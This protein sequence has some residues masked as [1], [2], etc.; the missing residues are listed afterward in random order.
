VRLVHLPHKSLLI[1]VLFDD[2]PFIVICDS[3]V[4]DPTKQNPKKRKMY[5]GINK[6]LRWFNNSFVMCWKVI[7]DKRLMY[8]V[9]YKICTYV[10]GKKKTPNSKVEQFVQTCWLVETHGVNAWSWCKFL[11][12]QQGFGVC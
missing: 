10:E 9:H 4:E 1:I 7:D 11:S 2:S 3:I 5:K 8:Q 12:L 6:K